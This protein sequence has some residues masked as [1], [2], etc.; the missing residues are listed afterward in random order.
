MHKKWSFPIKI[1]LLNVTKPARNCEFGPF[2]EEFVNGEL[3]FFF[4]FLQWI[5]CHCWNCFRYFWIYDALEKFFLWPIIPTMP[6]KRTRRYY[7]RPEKINFAGIKRYFQENVFQVFPVLLKKIQ[8]VLSNYV[9]LCTS[10]QNRLHYQVYVADPLR[11]IW[12]HLVFSWEK[13]TLI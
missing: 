7:L 9:R 6:M 5:F 10:C 12:K 8:I 11:Q 1:S 3:H 13:K 4:V 2:T